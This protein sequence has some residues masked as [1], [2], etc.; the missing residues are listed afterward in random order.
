LILTSNAG[1]EFLEVEL[2]T[3]GLGR[4]FSQIFSATSDFGEVKKTTH[5]YDRICR[6]LG[7]TPEEIIHVGD[8]FEFDYLVPRSIGIQ[9]F[10]LDRSGQRNGDSFLR[11]LVDLEKEL[12]TEGSGRGRS[13]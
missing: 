4:Y 5:V 8:H 9:A 13:W 1:R 11:S 7:V 6:M 12:R 3:T 10:F 2:N